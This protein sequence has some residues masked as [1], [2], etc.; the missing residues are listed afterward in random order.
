MTAKQKNG[1]ELTSSRKVISDLKY[2]WFYDQFN[3]SG[4]KHSNLFISLPSVFITIS[5]FCYLKL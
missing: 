4:N 2:L 1:G 3:S 5:I